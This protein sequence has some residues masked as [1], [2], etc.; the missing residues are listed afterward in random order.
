MADTAPSA[1]TAP[2]SISYLDDLFA[3]LTLTREV[4][5]ESSLAHS[6]DSSEGSLKAFI[7]ASRAF[8][9]TLSEAIDISLLLEQDR[10]VTEV[11]S[12]A[13][14]LNLSNLAEPSHAGAFCSVDKY[15][16]ELSMATMKAFLTTYPSVQLPV[17]DTP[18]YRT[19]F[20]QIR[21]MIESVQKEPDIL[22]LNWDDRRLDRM[23]LTLVIIQLSRDLLN[24]KFLSLCYN[25]AKEHDGEI[26]QAQ[27]V[28]ADEVNENLGDPAEK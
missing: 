17:P 19:R 6:K 26:Q 25:V 5:D 15:A 22:Y 24:K 3:R 16:V 1:D 2:G 28:V 12:V 27:A 23:A 14:G 11:E 8:R 10:N 4:H 21:A 9:N 20:D 7:E 13:P 18:S